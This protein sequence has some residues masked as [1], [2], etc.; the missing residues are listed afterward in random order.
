MDNNGLKKSKK[1][2]EKGMRGFSADDTTNEILQKLADNGYN[3]SAVI[4]KAILDLWET[5]LKNKIAAK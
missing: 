3:I 2:Y 1:S 4:R 5:E